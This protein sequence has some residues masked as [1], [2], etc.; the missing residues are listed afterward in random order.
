M[1]L[2]E[3]ITS[4]NTATATN[5]PAILPTPAP[6]FNDPVGAALGRAEVVGAEL[7][8]PLSLSEVT[9]RHLGRVGGGF[10]EALGASNSPANPRPFSKVWFGSK[11]HWVT[12][13]T[14]FGEGINVYL[15]EV[16]DFIAAPE[17]GPGVQKLGDRTQ[18]HEWNGEIEHLETRG[19]AL[20]MSVPASETEM[21]EGCQST[22]SLALKISNTLRIEM[23]LVQLL[24]ST[25]ME[26]V[27]GFYLCGVVLE[28]GCDK[29]PNNT[30]YTWDDSQ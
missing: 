26:N 8:E 25:T 3:A 12:G 11:R 13:V 15:L 5:P 23:L 9:V 1:S 16:T 21:I 4:A 24:Q 6:V 29:P 18:L 27:M 19:G 17:S 20:S 7:A 28:L 10:E 30:M 22:A 14:G 2:N